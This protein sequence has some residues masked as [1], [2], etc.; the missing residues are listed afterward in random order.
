MTVALLVSRLPHTLSLVSDD[1]SAWL[2]SPTIVELGLRRILSL[3]LPSFV[4][5]VSEV[6]LT[7]LAWATMVPLVS[8]SRIIDARIAVMSVSIIP[9]ALSVVSAA[10]TIR[11][12]LSMSVGFGLS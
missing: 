3:S 5:D 12:V 2:N 10:L 9:I 4:S 11:L 7:V 6:S 1:L 8:S